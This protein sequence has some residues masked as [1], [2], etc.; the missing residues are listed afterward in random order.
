MTYHFADKIATLKP[1]AVREILKSAN[2]PGMI[3]FS[4]GN[5]AAESFPVEAI[6]QVTADILAS[7]SNVA[8][9]YGITEG[10]APL[11]EKI[12]SRDRARH[13]VGRDFDQTIITSGAQEAIDFTARVLCNEGDTVLCENPSFVGALNAFRSYNVNLVGIP[14]ES[15][16]LDLNA[17]EHALKTEKNVRFLYVIPNFQ[18]P[19]GITTSLEKRRA[20]YELAKR[21]GIMILE[22]NPY[23]ELR[24]AGQD[25]PAIKSMDEDG[26]VIYCGSF[27]KILSSGLRVGYATAPAAVVSKMVI[28]KQCCDVH[29]TLLS[30]M[31]ADEF[32]SNYDLEAHLQK[33]RDLYRE[34]SSCMLA[35]IDE[36]FDARVTTTRPEGGL[37]LW[38]TLPEGCD[39]AAFAKLLLERK[40]AVVPGQ[41]FLPN[42]S[43]QTTSFRMN[44]STPSMENIRAGI[45]IIGD[46]MKT[47]LK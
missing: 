13:H 33:I 1:S 4:A 16:G 21:Y 38:S 22:D 28:A 31:I 24:F 27:S 17:L 6:Q 43:D 15:D 42:E 3:A 45:A 10:Y 12:T 46:V 7:R 41:A 30:Q 40:V 44:Y 35:C 5:P 8:L 37:F 26:I 29:T 34:K 32:L 20:I 39:V 2:A 11:I 19:A 14:L 23:G 18:N 47:F 36:H 25:V 9:Q